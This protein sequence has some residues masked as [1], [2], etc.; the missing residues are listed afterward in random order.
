VV[1]SG[2]EYLTCSRKTCNV[3]E[4]VTLEELSYSLAG[5]QHARCVVHN[6]GLTSNGESSKMRHVRII[7]RVSADAVQK[8]QTTFSPS[9]IIDFIIAILTGLKPILTAKLTPAT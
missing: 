8:A 5:R 7:S 6:E 2:V 3:R 9:L 4:V 1:S